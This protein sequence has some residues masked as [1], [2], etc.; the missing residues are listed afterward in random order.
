MKPDSHPKTFQGT[1]VYKAHDVACFN[2]P[3]L[4]KAAH[5]VLQ[6]SVN[7]IQEPLI[8]CSKGIFPFLT[9]TYLQKINRNNLPSL[10]RNNCQWHLN[11]KGS[12]YNSTHML[13]DINTIARICMSKTKNMFLRSCFSKFPS[14]IL[15]SMYLNKL[16]DRLDIKT[17]GINLWSWYAVQN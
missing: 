6:H 11:R 2:V 12:T 9:A 14:C 16:K 7:V 15:A 10:W 4:L 3:A 8:I 5:Q 17:L 13:S 1:S